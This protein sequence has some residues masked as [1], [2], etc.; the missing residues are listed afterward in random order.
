MYQHNIVIL[1]GTIQF[2]KIVGEPQ[3]FRLNS[4]KLT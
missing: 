1:R 2:K 4:L 3:I